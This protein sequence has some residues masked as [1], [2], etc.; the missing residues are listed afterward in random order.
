MSVPG[1]GRALTFWDSL[2]FP[3]VRRINPGA[4]EKTLYL[5]FD[6]GPDP[7]GTPAVLNTLR[8]LGVSATFFLVAEKMRRYPEI[9]RRIRVEGHAIGNHSLD[10]GY[11]E[12]FTSRESINDWVRAAEEAFR[13]QGI[14]PV[15]FRPPAGVRTPKLHCALYDLDLPLILWSARFFDTRFPW[16]RE[17]AARALKRLDPGAIILLHDRQPRERLDLFVETLRFFVNEARA[18]GFEFRSLSRLVCDAHKTGVAPF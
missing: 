11:R 5:T 14:E 7:V 6:D 2:F 18:S 17:R 1:G 16:T 15:G 3:S 9:T 10:H 13:E 12:F 8:A 4:N